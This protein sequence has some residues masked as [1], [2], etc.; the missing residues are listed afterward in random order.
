MLRDMPVAA[1]T[2][3]GLLL[4]QK[5]IGLTFVSMKNQLIGLKQIK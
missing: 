2:R 4:R 3:L 1:Q 5:H